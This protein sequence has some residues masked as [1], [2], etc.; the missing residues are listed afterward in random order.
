M[1]TITC[2]TCNESLAIE[3]WELRR[4]T[5]QS[6]SCKQCGR[7]IELPSPER[8]N[9]LEIARWKATLDELAVQLRAD[10]V[11]VI[12]EYNG[13][14]DEGCFESIDCIDKDLNALPV[15]PAVVD[16]FETLF[17]EM[18]ESVHPG[19]EINDGSSGKFEIDVATRHVTNL[20][21]QNYMEQFEDEAEW[22][23]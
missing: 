10:A 13:S 8:Y 15:P 5:D 9:E 1:V 4:S 18:L 11:A 21:R 19:W 12:A 17:S 20:N 14:G 7:E 2:P 6:V 3:S 22:K 23:L 16:G